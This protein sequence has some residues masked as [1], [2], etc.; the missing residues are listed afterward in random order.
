[1]SAS[2]ALALASAWAEAC[3]ELRIVTDER[4]SK[5]SVTMASK[6]MVDRVAIKTKPGR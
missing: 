2:R 3:L 1:M 4:V 6:I 5:A